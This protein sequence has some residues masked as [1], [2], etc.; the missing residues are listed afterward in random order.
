[1]SCAF[2]AFASFGSETGRADKRTGK[3]QHRWIAAKG[4]NIYRVDNGQATLIHTIAAVGTQSEQGLLCVVFEF[5]FSPDTHD[6]PV[7]QI[8]GVASKL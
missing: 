6:R 7:T 1:M 4:G 5:A 8:A 3:P 2:S